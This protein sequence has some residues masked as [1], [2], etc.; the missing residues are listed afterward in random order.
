MARVAT[1]TRL[2]GTAVTAI[3]L[4][5]LATTTSAA[6]RPTGL[7]GFVRMGPITPVC[8]E[9]IPCDGPAA[10]VLLTFTRA[11]GTIVRVKTRETGFYRIRLPAGRYSVKANRGHPPFPYPRN[12]RVRAGYDDRLDFHIDTGIQ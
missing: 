9:D 2:L 7:H 4:L 3:V 10:G 5:L 12:V 8:Y 6:T 11:D 1:R